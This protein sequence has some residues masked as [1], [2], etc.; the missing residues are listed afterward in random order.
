MLFCC[1]DFVCYTE[2]TRRRAVG[3]RGAAVNAVDNVKL[4][5]T[6][7]VFLLTNVDQA[8]AS[9]VF[10]HMRSGEKAN[11]RY[12]FLQFI[13]TC[14]RNGQLVAG[15][16]LVL[17]NA[18]IHVAADTMPAFARLMAFAQV[19]VCFLPSYSPE[20]NPCELVFAQ[21]KHYLRYHRRMHYPFWYEIARG[22][23][24]TSSM[25]MLQ[26][27]YKCIWNV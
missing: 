24:E 10:V 17:D 19:S 9:P 14:L 12:D 6:I 26:Y 3:P 23:A 5:E 25:H 13:I 2:L 20:L 21:C 15:D 4:G 22:F 27:Y 18:P 16:V 7:K 8:Q 1:V 11:D